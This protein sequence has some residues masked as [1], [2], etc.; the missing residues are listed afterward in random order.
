MDA[1]R[2]IRGRKVT[3]GHKIML[4]IMILAGPFGLMTKLYL[5]QVGKDIA[6]ASRE[7]EG[8]RYIE[9]LWPVLADMEAASGARVLELSRRPADRDELFKSR[10]AVNDFVAVATRRATP[11][12]V[13]EA[14]RAA[15]SKV[16]DGSNLTL[17]PDLDSYYLMDAVTVRMPEL[18]ASLYAL[19]EALKPYASAGA[20][21][22][23]AL[24]ALVAA[25]TRYQA[26]QAATGGSIAAAMDGNPDGLVR[27]ALKDV[28]AAAEGA[29][30]DADSAIARLLAKAE[31]GQPAAAAESDQALV[32]V[33]GA[34]R[35]LWTKAEGELVRL[36]QARIAG[37]EADRLQKMAIVGFALALGALALVMVISSIRRPL[38]GVLAAIGR[39]QAGDYLSAV[40]GTQLN[41]EFG[42][43]ARALRKLQGMSGEQAL[44]TAGI[45]GSGMMLMITDSEDRIIFLSNGLIQLFMEL[46]PQFRAAKEDFSVKGMYGEKIDYYNDNANLKRE[47]MSDDGRRRRVRYEVGGHVIDVD[48]SNVQD[49]TGHRVGSVLVWTDITAELAAEREIA[50]IVDAAGQGDFSRRVSM[51]GK[52]SAAREIAQGLNAF[53]DLVENAS[54][55]FAESLTALAA[56]DLT[57]PVAN[58]YD[59]VFG[60]LQEAIND[61]IA[62]LAD[63]IRTI[64]RTASEVATAANEIQYGSNDLARRTEDQA[65]SLEENAATTEELAASVKASAQSARQ[66]A[67]LA[68]RA[69]HSASEGGVV[70]SQAVEAISR[71]EESSRRIADITSVI[72]DIAFQTNLLALNAAVEAARA[73]EAGKGF[74]VVASEVRT[75]AQRSSEAAKDITGLI[76]TSTAEV[77]G[78][79]KLVKSAGDALEQIVQASKDVFDTIAEISSSTA[80]QATGIDEISSAIS[81]LDATTQ[82]NAALA[83]ESAASAASLTTQIQDLERLVAGFRTGSDRTAAARRRAA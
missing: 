61:T 36:L 54:K 79:V 57:R 40:P 33:Q 28:N 38:G 30:K 60:R 78:G 26:A 32:Q 23:G 42:E 16:A 7:V 67:A 52:K 19:R 45:N 11:S 47:L 75:L 73:G 24:R 18:M 4:I 5:D 39:F 21:S 3:V 74:A 65:A 63:T 35:G 41:N 49:D 44:T 29:W 83:E 81:T 51:D 72:D 64:Q 9:A 48:M 20:P 31:A 53:A 2:L 77:V 70:V 37:F 14:G 50:A 1:L 13:A 80:E 22:G 17:D 76:T 62:R 27:A 55:D 25:S 43:I 82:Q 68:E 6:F 71:I 15:I 56:G 34:V 46:E 10:E 12:A 69:K 66:A 59:G 8:A 58:S